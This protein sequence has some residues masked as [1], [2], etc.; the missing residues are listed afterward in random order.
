M[1]SHVGAGDEQK[2]R[3]NTG[4]RH[5]RMFAVSVLVYPTDSRKENQPVLVLSVDVVVVENRACRAM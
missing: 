3:S 4:P 5:T 1:Q 2:P